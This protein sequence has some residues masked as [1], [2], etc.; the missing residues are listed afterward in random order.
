MSA[1]LVIDNADR[2]KDN[3]TADWGLKLCNQC[4][5][6]YHAEAI[7]WT[8]KKIHLLMP[9]LGI[10]TNR[11]WEQ[12]VK[13]SFS[14]YRRRTLLTTTVRLQSEKK[15]HRWNKSAVRKRGKGAEEGQRESTQ[16]GRVQR[17][18]EKRGEGGRCRWHERNKEWAK[19]RERMTEREQTGSSEESVRWKRQSLALYLLIPFPGHIPWGSLF[20][21]L[22]NIVPLVHSVDFIFAR[23]SGSRLRHS[24]PENTPFL[25]ASPVPSDWYS[26]MWK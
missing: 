14:V 23:S 24:T 5:V 13:K 12:S 6:S 25:A 11:G 8:S 16:S 26:L 2:I 3:N 9:Q 22:I 1:Y 19:G 4:S 15:G 10:S 20:K 17:R 21:Y 18:Q 7:K